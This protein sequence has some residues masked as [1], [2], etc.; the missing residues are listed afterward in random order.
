MVS[1]SWFQVGLSNGEGALFAEGR[2]HLNLPLRTPT[3]C[4]AVCSQYKIPTRSCF[5]KVHPFLTLV[6]AASC[7]T[8]ELTSQP[9]TFSFRHRANRT[10]G[11]HR[12]STASTLIR[13]RYLLRGSSLSTPFEASKHP[14]AHWSQKNRAQ[15]CRGSPITDAAWTV[16]STT[17]NRRWQVQADNHR[18]Y[19]SS[20]S[21]NTRT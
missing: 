12:E 5:L 6:H 13:A 14:V 7:C 20:E 16:L 1:I 11:R 15:P 10:R 21:S 8:Q 9:G 2:Y 18:T 19:P 3:A 4:V 17:I